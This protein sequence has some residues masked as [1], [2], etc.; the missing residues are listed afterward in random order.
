MSEHAS[1]IMSV[2][3]FFCVWAGYTLIADSDQMQSKSILG[4]MNNHRSRWM[5][6]MLRRDPRMVDALILSH[7]QAGIALFASTSLLAVG[8]L[9]ALLGAAEKAVATLSALPFVGEMSHFDWEM[10]VLLLL[11]ISVYAFFKFIWSYRLYSICAVLIGAVPSSAKID[12]KA[13]DQAKQAAEILNLAA[14]HFIRGVRA[15]YFA[16]A[17]LAW[18]IHPITFMAATVWVA[19]VMYRRDFRSRSQRIVRGDA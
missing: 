1:D 9:L 14:R 2:L 6:E 10:K 8:G 3:W 15:F 5:A 17:A 4:L 16:L 7:L 18:L 19:V 12:E 11:L 13:E